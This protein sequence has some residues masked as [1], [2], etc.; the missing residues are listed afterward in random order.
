MAKH[1]KHDPP[2]LDDALEHVV[3][4]MWK[5]KQSVGYY[6]PIRHVGSDAAIEFRVLHHRVLL[7]FFYGRPTHEDN[8][9]AWEYINGWN[10]A[11]EVTKVPGLND[12]MTRCHTML[13]HI[14]KTRT[15]IAKRGLKSWGN[16]W[17]IVEPHLDQLISDF[18]GGL[19]IHHKQICRN[20]VITW[21]T[22]PYP[23]NDSLGDL[24]AIL[25]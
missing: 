11:H 4:E 8:I 7:D 20:W 19:T 12:Y 3:Y 9:V 21:S 23:C 22:G 17:S 14:S 16:D 18:L 5:Y 2:D 13:A 24:L 25:S 10:Q 15:E 1:I 6:E